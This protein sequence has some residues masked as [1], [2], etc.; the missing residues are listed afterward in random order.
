MRSRNELQ[1]GLGGLFCN[2]RWL[3][4]LALPS[5]GFPLLRDNKDVCGYQPIGTHMPKYGIED[6]MVNG[7]GN[8]PFNAGYSFMGPPRSMAH[9][10]RHGVFSSE[11]TFIYRFHL[12]NLS[13]PLPQ[14]SVYKSDRCASNFPEFVARTRRGNVQNVT[15]SPRGEGRRLKNAKIYGSNNRI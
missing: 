2:I 10:H 3:R 11:F 15:A 6:S 13:R 8:M 12:F 5:L 7:G 4:V 9:R 14:E 1:D